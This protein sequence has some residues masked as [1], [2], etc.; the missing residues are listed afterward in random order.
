[1]PRWPVILW[2]D[3]DR[4]GGSSAAWGCSHLGARLGWDIQDS[5]STCDKKPWARLPLVECL[6]IEKARR[7]LVLR[8]RLWKGTGGRQSQKPAPECW[9]AGTSRQ[10]GWLECWIAGPFFLS[11]SSPRAPL[12]LLWF[13]H[14]LFSAGSCISHKADQGSQKHKSRI[15]QGFW[16]LSLDLAQHHSCHILLVKTTTGQPRFQRRGDK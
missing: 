12:S 10:L 4:L 7:A 16:S 2:V 3:W 9:A 1:M 5:S 13:L 14:G 6:G 11:P 15:C 8:T